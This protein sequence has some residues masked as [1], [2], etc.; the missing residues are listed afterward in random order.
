MT[1]YAAGG[2]L[3][4]FIASK[5]PNGVPEAIVWRIL[6]QLCLALRSTH[7]KR[8]VH[9]DMNPRNV[10]IDNSNAIRL[11][12][13]ALSSLGEPLSTISGSAL[14]MSPELCS[15]GTHNEKTDIWALGVV[16]Y[17][18]CTGKHPF[19]ASNMPDLAAQIRS[20]KPVRLSVDN[21]RYACCISFVSQPYTCIYVC[22]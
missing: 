15:G 8:I 14:Y 20:G 13:F 9:G 12:Q 7:S 10:F 5:G 21:Y 4:D 3:T 1:E 2:S 17:E 11:G 6:L 22:F 16:I 18:C 19:T